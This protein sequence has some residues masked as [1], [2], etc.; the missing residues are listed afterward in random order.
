MIVS[1]IKL[2][3]ENTINKIAAG[4]VVERPA[5]IVKELVENAIDAE[6]TAIT[7]EIKEGG[8]GLIR[9]TDNGSGI[10]QGDIKNAFYRHSTS[11]ITG[12]DDLQTVA[13]LGFRGEA[14]ASIASISQVELITKTYGSLTGTRYLIEGGIEK[15]QEEIGC[16]DGT[17]FIVRNVFYNTPVRKK[18][19]KSPVTE[20]G[21]IN[22]LANKL[23]LGN[24]QISFK[25]VN[26][27]QVKLHTS[28][29]N[30]AKDAIFNVFGK[31]IAKNL[32]E[33]AFE[34]EV[35]SVHGFI[36]K[37][38]I[39]RGNRN[40]ENYYI[41]NRYIKSKVLNKAIEEAYKSKLTL[42]KYPFVAL[43]IRID[44]RHI[45]VNVHPTKMDIRFNNEQDVYETMFK[46]IDEALRS[47]ELIPEVN[48]E[49]KANRQKIVTKPHIPEPFEVQRRALEQQTFP[50]IQEK[51][52][53]VN[54]VEKEIENVTDVNKVE[55]EIE[56]TSSYEAIPLANQ[57]L[58]KENSSQ[59]NS[60]KE[61]VTPKTV[62]TSEQIKL[63]EEVFTDAKSLSQHKI[64]G[65]LFDTYWIVEFKEKYYIIDQ[66]AAHEKVLYEK[67]I[68]NLES[69]KIVS[70]GLLEAQIVNLSINEYE[71][72]KTH[73]KLFEQLGF[74]IDEFGQDSLIIRGVPY[75][76]DQPIDAN[77]F[78][79]IIDKLENQYLEEKYD[80]LLE[81]I[82]SMSCKAAVKA[83]D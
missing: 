25:F 24:P 76:F 80:I 58:I 70:Q 13:S 15:S 6:A 18:F 33:V 23:A 30:K 71:R 61:M 22:E 16:P 63:E 43:Y 56:N 59:L 48:F 38:L 34:N 5:S 21:Y 68:K 79:A 28:G 36:G 46:A 7:I 67:I 82:A 77:D 31:D 53:V 11:K 2:L 83:N 19:L 37:P 27:H 9:I 20:A 62:P 73:R 29:N 8:L 4:E 49:E 1:I 81:H 66:H 60:S 12:V 64:V 55:K 51:S 40:Y 17:T 45:D 3:D 44:P 42:H 26:N 57:E 47:S 14:L 39:S 74:E 41:N 10:E 52:T 78:L 75:I 35:L 69:A 54:K 72:F 32:I 65:H 50:K